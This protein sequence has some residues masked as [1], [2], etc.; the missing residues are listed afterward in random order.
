MNIDAS[1]LKKLSYGLFLLSSETDGRDNACIINTAQQISEDPM[2]I[3]VTVNKSTQ[4]HKMIVS[5]GKLALSILS[6][7]VDFSLIRRFGFES[8]RDKNKFADFTSV[9]RASNG[10]LYATEG[11]NGV[12][13]ASVVQSLD[14]ATHT[15]FI[16]EVAETI[17]LNDDPS[18]T[19]AY[20]F[21]HIKPRSEAP[22]NKYVCTICGYVYDG[23]TLPEDYVCPICYHGS[24]Y[25]EKQ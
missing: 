22:K 9:A 1:V 25:F 7:K 16:A 2:L 5:S 20:Y 3:S 19:Y 8:G 12:I 18:A 15:L 11:T 14:C 13:T 24:E 6:E 17:A 23:D 4:T 10:C 21:E